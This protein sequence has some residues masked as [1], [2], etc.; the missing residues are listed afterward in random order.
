M[1]DVAYAPDVPRAMIESLE[2]HARR[3]GLALADV[4]RIGQSLDAVERFI[5]ASEAGWGAYFASA[6]G[7][8]GTLPAPPV[9]LPRARSPRN[10][11]MRGGHAA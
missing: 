7:A 1:L 5:V 3:L 2:H 9:V 11:R 10:W 4:E 6:L 8:T